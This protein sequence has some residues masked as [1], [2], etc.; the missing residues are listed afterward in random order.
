MPG[1]VTRQFPAHHWIKKADDGTIG[2]DGNRILLSARVAYRN[3][4][5][6]EHNII[7]D[8]RGEGGAHQLLLMKGHLQMVTRNDFTTRP[9]PTPW[10]L[11]SNWGSQEMV[12]WAGSAMFPPKPE[13][14][15]HINRRQD[16][17]APLNR[18]QLYLSELAG[19]GSQT[20]LVHVDGEDMTP[21]FDTFQVQHDNGAEW[22]A[23]ENIFEWHLHE[24]V[25]RLCVRA[26]NS[27]GVVGPAS[28]CVIHLAQ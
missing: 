27:C 18:A 22:D 20:L 26:R 28:S 10:R 2:D 9:H 7:G 3:G 23:C 16:W 11:S 14:Q 8:T 25:N 21:C 5:R 1:P 12:A 24:G 17:S 6:H 15:R 4:D 13:Y 19:A